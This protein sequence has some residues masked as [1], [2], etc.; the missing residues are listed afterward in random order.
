MWFSIAV[1]VTPE[2]GQC[3]FEWVLNA[4]ADGAMALFI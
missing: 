1:W 4:S 2:L 3:D